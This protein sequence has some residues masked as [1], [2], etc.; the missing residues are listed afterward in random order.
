MKVLVVHAHP[1]SD[2]LSVAL[3]DATLAGLGRAG[4]EVIRHD[5]AAD[6]LRAAM[7]AEERLRYHDSD[8]PADPVAGRYAADVSDVEAMVFVFPTWWFGPPA[9]LKGWF[10]RVLVHGVAFDLIDGKLSSRLRHV[11]RLAGVTTT[12]SPRWVVRLSGDGG[13]RTVNRTLRLM[14]SPRCRTSW[15]SLHAVDSRDRGDCEAFVQRV[16]D[17]FARW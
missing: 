3:R 2:S 15:Y 10:D 11:R 14:C 1:G 5:L 7:S 13:R 9:V 16:E 6:G 12:G 4:H 17:G 8:P